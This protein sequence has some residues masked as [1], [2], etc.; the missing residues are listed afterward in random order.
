MHPPAAQDNPPLSL[1]VVGPLLLTPGFLPRLPFHADAPG[2]ARVTLDAL[3][4]VPLV[5]RVNMP[6]LK[7][8]QTLC[9]RTLLWM[10]LT[11]TAQ[12]TLP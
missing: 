10:V 6:I 5:T 8:F 12:E 2:R 7:L 11:L 1:P 9:A 3:G 4:A